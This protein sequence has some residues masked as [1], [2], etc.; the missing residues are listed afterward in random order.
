MAV[1]G[2]TM[3]LSSTARVTRS[4]IPISGLRVRSSFDTVASIGKVRLS[5]SIVLPTK[6]TSAVRTPAS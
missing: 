4:L 6:V 5:G 1:R 2:T 3:V